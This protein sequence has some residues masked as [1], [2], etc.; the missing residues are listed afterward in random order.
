MNL[1]EE[2][3]R[4][5][6]INIVP[7][8]DIIFAVLAFFILS[9]LFL[10]RAEGLPVNLPSAATSEPQQDLTIVVSLNADGAIF[11][12][13][14]AVNITTLRDDISQ[15]MAAGQSPQ[16]TLRADESVTHGRVITVMDTLRQI[17]GVRI[18]IATRSP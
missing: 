12:N 5:F 11:L 16:V 1:P 14:T 9:T 4:R 8:I 18:G 6:Q 10:T 13:D 15:L 2:P 17:E 3:E 7:M